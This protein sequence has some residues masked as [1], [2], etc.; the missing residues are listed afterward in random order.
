MAAVLDIAQRLDVLRSS[1]RTWRY[2]T[3]I[4]D[5]LAEIAADLFG[6][7]I[8][9]VTLFDAR[10]SMV[11]GGSRHDAR[12]GRGPQN[13]FCVHTIGG[14]VD[15]TALLSAMPQPTLVFPASRRWPARHFCGFMLGVPL[16]HR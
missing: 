15:A 5:E 2:R 6:A 1:S 7:P 14:P 12:H 8:A 11:Q 10:R 16:V 4:S 9:L 13:S 3:P